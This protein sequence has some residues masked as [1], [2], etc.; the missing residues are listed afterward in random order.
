[1]NIP[2]QWSKYCKFTV[3]ALI[4][5][6]VQ[7]VDTGR[8]LREVTSWSSAVNWAGISCFTL[9]HQGNTQQSVTGFDPNRA[10]L[11]A[12]SAAQFLHC[13]VL[14]PVL[15]SLPFSSCFPDLPWLRSTISALSASALVW[16]TLSNKLSLSLSSASRVDKYCNNYS[17]EHSPG[18]H[19][20]LYN[21]YV[22]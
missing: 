4:K 20:S 15:L 22:K 11:S 9:Q 19:C 7:I 13:D 8:K 1:M 14:A 21:N 3:I 6:A 18:G 17:I 16:E 10:N 12:P 5:L 2:F